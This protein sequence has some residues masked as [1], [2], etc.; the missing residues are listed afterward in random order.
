MNQYLLISAN[1]VNSIAVGV[2]VVIV[3]DIVVK[4]AKAKGNRHTIH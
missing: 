1:V 4:Q 2:T 3:I